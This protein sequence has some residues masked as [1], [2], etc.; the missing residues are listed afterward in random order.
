[1]LW[2]SLMLQPNR[3]PLSVTY[4]YIYMLHTVRLPRSR[5]PSIKLAYT[6]LVLFYNVC[7]TPVHHRPLLA[8]LTRS[9]PTFFGSQPVNL[10]VLRDKYQLNFVGR[11]SAKHIHDDI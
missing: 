11:V 6:A 4:I 5:A 8:D 1:M 10:N 7:F 9:T 2:F 3:C